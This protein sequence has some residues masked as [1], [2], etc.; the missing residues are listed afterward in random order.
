M[1]RRKAISYK[2][3]KKELALLRAK[4]HRN[5]NEIVDIKSETA[6]IRNALDSEQGVELYLRG[7]RKRVEKLEEEN[8]NDAV[9][10]EELEKELPKI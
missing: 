5:Y 4:S 6:I 8:R 10:I 1:P 3:L 2:E 7:L 9:R